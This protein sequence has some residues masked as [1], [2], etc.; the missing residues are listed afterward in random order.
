MS[1]YVALLHWLFVKENL[2][3]SC[4]GCV[5]DSDHLP[6]PDAYVSTA[7]NPEG[8]VEGIMCLK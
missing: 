2:E 5:D 6:S 3:L 4:V 7:A 1:A 8:V